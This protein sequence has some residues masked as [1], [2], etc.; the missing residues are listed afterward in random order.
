MTLTEHIDAL[1]KM[2]ADHASTA[3][4]RSQIAF[5]GREVAAL[6]ADYTNLAENNAKLQASLSL[7]LA[8][9]S[10]SFEYRRG[11]Y[12]KTNDPI[13]F[14]PHCWETNNKKIHLSGP[15]PM[16]DAAVEYWEC[17]ACNKDYHAK[18]GENFL[19]APARPGR[20]R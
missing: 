16:S 10:D 18:S 19:A 9:R 12:F 8:D 13:P 11:L 7:P 17:H 15:V 4:I 14:C 20:R 5:I 2:V 1:D 6:E 3:E